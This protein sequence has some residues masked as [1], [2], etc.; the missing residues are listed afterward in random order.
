M[1][2]DDDSTYLGGSNSSNEG[3]TPAHHDLAK[4]IDV[5]RLGS[6]ERL[7]SAADVAATFGNDDHSSLDNRTISLDPV[8]ARDSALTQ[9][10]HGWLQ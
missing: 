6:F 5:T 2:T 7:G 1:S 4:R 8:A 9:T 3:V 10:S